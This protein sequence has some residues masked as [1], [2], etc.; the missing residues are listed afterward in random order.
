MRGV[1]PAIVSEI[2]EIMTIIQMVMKVVQM[3]QQ[4]VSQAQQQSMQNSPASDAEA[5]QLT[6][7]GFRQQSANAD[8]NSDPNSIR[9][10]YAGLFAQQTAGALLQNYGVNGSPTQML[11]SL[12]TDP[13]LSAQVSSMANTLGMT[14]QQLINVVASEVGIQQAA[15]GGSPTKAAPNTGLSG[16]FPSQYEGR[17]VNYAA[18]IPALVA[19]QVPSIP[20]FAG[21]LTPQLDAQGVSPSAFSRS[22][23]DGSFNRN[24]SPAQSR[25]IERAAAAVGMSSD[26]FLK[27]VASEVDRIQAAGLNTPGRTI[28]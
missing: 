20:T 11:Q 28:V 16:V 22:L 26:E 3:V 13:Q 5:Q 25:T 10:K 4:M 24:L 27:G 1:H 18:R 21:H 9:A 15:A 6:D 2:S 23:A 17:G 19:S 7:P 8:D 14:P 12:S